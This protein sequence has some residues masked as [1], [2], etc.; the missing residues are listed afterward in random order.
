MMVCSGP[1]GRIGL[2]DE[3]IINPYS[4]RL[5]DCCQTR[6]GRH[7]LV[8]LPAH[9]VPLRDTSPF[10]ELL[11]RQMRPVAS[12]EDPSAKTVPS[13]HTCQV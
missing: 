6:P 3:Q 12:P 8:V 9:D 10:G 11:L 5:G 1:K 7:V 4:G 2:G 13:L